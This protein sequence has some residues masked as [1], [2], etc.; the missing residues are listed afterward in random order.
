MSLRRDTIDNFWFVLRHEIEH[1]L[2]KD[3]VSGGS[4]VDAQ[5]RDSTE[6]AEIDPEE[7]IA[8]D[9][10]EEFCVPRAELDHF[11]ARVGTAVSEQRVL[12]FAQRLGVHPGL[13]VGQLQ[14]RFDRYNFLTH[15][16]A[17]ARD[18][19]IAGALTDG[20]GRQLLEAVD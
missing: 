10:A 15:H 18:I 7:V 12:S 17:K 1:V 4:V 9:A 6:K 16:L 2:R 13:V 3:A 20:Y 14:F 11:L 8:N 5:L 19:V